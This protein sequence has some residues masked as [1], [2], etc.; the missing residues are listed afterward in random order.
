MTWRV[1]WIQ[2]VPFEHLGQLEPLL[3]GRGASFTCTRAY[4]G[5]PYP[6]PEDYDALVVM[7]GPMS[8]NDDAHLPWIGTEIACIEAAIER[9]RMV[10]GVCLGAQMITR[11]LG[12]A[13]VDNG[14]REIG[15]FGLEPYPDATKDP[16]VRA[17]CKPSQVLHWHGEVA[18]L[19]A[20]ATALARSEGCSLQA[21]RWRQ[22][23]LALQFHLEMTRD[24][25]RELVEACRHELNPPARF[26]QYAEE[27]VG[28]EQQFVRA[29]AALEVLIEHFLGPGKPTEAT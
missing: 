12:A 29:H 17:M 1:H 20:G 8:V 11:A 9:E 18:V 4:G 5:E 22:H 25:A 2:H 21:Y 14:Q 16:L 3:R 10:L 24:G 26:V 19:P 13:V 6:R 28:A 23:V 7:G 27:I 15:W